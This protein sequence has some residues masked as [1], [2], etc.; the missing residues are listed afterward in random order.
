M[1]NM[2]ESKCKCMKKSAIPAGVIGALMIAMIFMI[3]TAISLVMSIP[4]RQVMKNYNYDVLV[5]SV[6][7]VHGALCLRM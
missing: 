2:N 3:G 1:N 6:C 4:I 5:L 7:F